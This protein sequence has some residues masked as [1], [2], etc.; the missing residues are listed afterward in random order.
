MRKLYLNIVLFSLLLGMLILMLTEIELPNNYL[1][2]KTYDTDYKKISWNINLIS[3]NPEKIKDANLFFGP[4]SIQCGICDSTLI[5]DGANSINMGINHSGKE[6]ELFFIEKTGVFKPKAIFVFANKT[7][8]NLHPMTPLLIKPSTLLKYGQT[9]NLTFFGYLADRTIFVLDY[10]RWKLSGETIDKIKFNTF[11]VVY[12]PG[13]MTEHEYEIISNKQHPIIIPQESTNIFTKAWRTWI[14]F[15]YNFIYNGASQKN[16][17]NKIKETASNYHL[18]IY[19]IYTPY[20]QDSKKTVSVPS[21][22]FLHEIITTK[23][24]NDFLFLNDAQYW[25]DEQHLSKS[26]A[27]KFTKQLRAN[28]IIK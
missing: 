13:E 25:F 17:I 27:I 15:K 19:A 16:F 3:N 11:G 20:C 28:E 10:F 8:I 14:Y 2:Y 24:L 12:E 23:K 22:F 5:A 21:T 4:S 18:P 7:V 9:I 6:L 1:I 26:G